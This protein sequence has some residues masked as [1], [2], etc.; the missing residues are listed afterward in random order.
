TMLLKPPQRDRDNGPGRL[1]RGYRSFLGWAIRARW[2]TFAVT[3]GAFA[4]AVAGLG[5][6][7]RQFFPPSDRVELLGD[8]DLPQNASVHATESVVQRF[9]QHLADDPDIHH[10]SSY[11]GRGAPRF[12]LP[13]N[14]QLA[15]PFFGQV[16]IVTKDIAARQRLQPRL[17][18][19]LADEFPSVVGRV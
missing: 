17:E 16:V 13:L 6:V 19:L 15:N 1:L 7:P 3:L 4:L 12:Y 14:V 8:L 11:V 18:K 10:F 2:V 9:E 5:L